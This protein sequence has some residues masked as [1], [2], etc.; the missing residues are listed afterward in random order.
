[1]RKPARSKVVDDI[2]VESSS[3]NLFRK[4]RGSGNPIVLL[5]GAFTTHFDWPETI[6]APLAKIGQVIA[7]DRPG[8]GH[9]PRRR[10]DGDAKAQARQIS[11]A[12]ALDRP[13]VVVGHSFGAL[14]ALAWAELFPDQVA[15]LIL[16]APV[17]F[18]EW[19]AEQLILGPRALP[20][21]GPGFSMATNPI[22]DR[23]CLKLIQRMM[24][25]P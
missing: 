12:L 20:F 1:M 21:I 13:A 9:S 18:P 6:T 16:I 5:H 22:L 10:F 25:A 7:V 14:P 2:E 4:M 15:G 11:S 3:S 17:C 23:L 19:R 24:F 8:H